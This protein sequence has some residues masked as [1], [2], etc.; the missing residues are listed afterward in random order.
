MITLKV[1]NG[2]AFSIDFNKQ[3]VILNGQPVA[4]DWAV[5]APNKYHVLFNHQSYTLELVSKDETGKQL[6]LMVNGQKHTVAIED[7]YDALLK[8][9]GMDKMV[10]NKVNEVKAPMPGLVLRILVKEGQ[11]VKKGDALLVLEAMKMENV[12][13]ATGEGVVKKITVQPKL[14]VD[15][16]QVMLVME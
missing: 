13:K 12:I 1:N 14:A 2:S 9:L 8:Q 6:V 15:K 5:I 16:N 4:S 3:E 10:A 7:Q 11:A